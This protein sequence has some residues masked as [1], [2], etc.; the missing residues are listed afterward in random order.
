M[1]AE[2]GSGD[3][4]VLPGGTYNG[5]ITKSEVGNGPKAPYIKVM[6]TIHDEEYKGW[7]VWGNATLSENAL[8]MPGAAPNLVQ[9]S[10]IKLE[11]DTDPKELPNVIA[12]AI[13]GQPVQVD[14]TQE[15]VKRNGELQTNDDG[16]PE[17]RAGIKK[18]H[19]APQEF[20]ESVELD[21]QGIDDDLPF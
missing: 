12:V 19:P 6:V 5:V 15:Q 1:G 17:M 13:K 2:V 21:A 18:Y 8:T 16:S 7:T 20:I 9:A 3:F 11:L 10:G 4:P 14:V